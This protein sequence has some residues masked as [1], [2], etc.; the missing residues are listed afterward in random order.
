MHKDII[1]VGAG[2][3]GLSLASNIRSFDVVIFEEHSKVGFPKH[4]AGIIGCETAEIVTS[5]ISPKIVDHGYRSV[6]F[7]TP[8]YTVKLVFRR[9]VAFHINRPL[10][11]EVL[12]SKAEALGHRIIFN[13]RA[14]PLTLG[15]V[16]ARGDIFKYKYL[17]VADGANS[18]FRR[19]LINEEQYFLTGLQLRVKVKGLDNDTL[20]IIYTSSLP[21]FFAWIIPLEDEAIIGA[22]SHSP[23]QAQRTLQYVQ[24]HLKISVENIYEK[25]GGLLPLHK[26]LRNPVLGGR[27]VFH[28]DSVPLIKPYTGG[29]LYHIFKLTPILA[30]HL[31]KYRLKDYNTFYTKFFYA[32]TIL[33]R[34]SVEFLRNSKQYSLPVK[35][36][37][38][39]KI[40]GLFQ[41]KDFDNHYLL[42]LKLIGTIPII[43]ALAFS[44]IFKTLYNTFG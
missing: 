9:E 25:F 5:T 18:L 22:A 44:D 16:L 7:K 40:L 1:I 17:V 31:E 39:L 24:K 14:R 19:I 4:C 20:Y 33:E 27:V 3:A 41:R 28:G 30:Q 6:L 12:A 10:L 37:N 2:P 15:E 13:T 11:E 42:L 26:P 38:W 29:G 21:E 35:I 36:V 8:N 34:T 23:M 32:K 43:G